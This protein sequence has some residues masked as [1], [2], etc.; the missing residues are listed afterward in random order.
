[1]QNVNYLL[2]YLSLPYSEKLKCTNYFQ[3]KVYLFP[4][5]GV[6]KLFV[7]KFLLAN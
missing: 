6:R 7:F 5:D 3:Y 2:G 1:M 4:K